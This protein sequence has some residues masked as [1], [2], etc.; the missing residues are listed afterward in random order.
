MWAA[1]LSHRRRFESHG[2]STAASVSRVQTLVRMKNKVSAIQEWVIHLRAT[3]Y[4][5]H[6]ESSFYK[7]A[8]FSKP[9]SIILRD[10]LEIFA[11]E[12]G[13]IHLNLTSV[14]SLNISAINVPTFWIS[15]LS[16]SQLS[17]TH[18]VTFNKTTC[19]HQG[20]SAGS[21]KQQI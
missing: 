10:R 21:T 2:S 4:I 20:H 17:A 3:H 6:S 7:L 19:Y 9:I 18:S 1:Q 13:K 12:R 15:L 14:Y 11:Y 8:A 16:I 5:C